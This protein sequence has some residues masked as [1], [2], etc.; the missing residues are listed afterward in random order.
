MV[1][2]PWICSEAAMRTPSTKPELEALRCDALAVC[3]RAARERLS[4]PLARAAAAFVESAGWQE[5]GYARLSDHARERFGRSGR[6]VSDLACLGRSLERLPGLAEAMS[7]QDAGPPLGRVAA[8]LVG[9]VATW[10]TLGSWVDLARCIC[11]RELKAAV[12]EALA[13]DPPSELQD[14]KTVLMRLAV[15]SPVQAAFDEAADL[16]RCVEGHESTLS[17]FVEALV[18]EAQACAIDPAPD[19]HM[20]TEPLR[21]VHH[22]ATVELALAH[23][24]ARWE[25][26]APELERFEEL[27]SAAGNG[28]AVELDA[29]IRELAWLEDEMER[30]LGALLAQ[31]AEGAAWSRLR[32]AG[33]G[34]YAEQR[35]GLCRTSAR[36]RLRA[37]RALRRLPV[38]RQAYESGVIGLQ[39]ALQVSRILL[40]AGAA[41]VDEATQ[42]LW[43]QRGAEATVKRMRDEAKELARQAVDGAG[44]ST[45]PLDDASWHASL[46]REPGM[47]RRRLARYGALALTT[48]LSDVFLGLRLPAELAGD[49]MAAMQAARRRLEIEAARVPWEEKWPHRDAP[50]SLRAAREFFII[51]NRRP[52]IWVG[53]LAMLEDFVHTWDQSARRK[54]EAI[55]ERDGYR[56]AAPGCT[57]RRNLED[58]HVLYRSQGGGNE[59]GNRICICRFHHQRGEHGGLASCHGEAPLR[60]TWRLGRDGAGGEFRNDRATASGGSGRG[61]SAGGP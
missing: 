19:L 29:Q 37:A 41:Q 27:E 36:D 59:A 60:I 42:Q 20:H 35:L 31:M 12:R 43:V 28:D 32:F 8:R 58:H 51:R 25:H 53:L 17:G 3:L 47:A 48:P 1:R 13:E 49:L 39:A 5:L 45:V 15:P 16:Y 34:H 10:E 9:Q 61:R 40:S 23:S 38:V 11:V 30:R 18:G 2:G 24:T 7:G 22:Q 6:W 44:G 14:Q 26:L 56:C 33:A 4:A 57:S 50:A 54:G 55:Y 46:R 52:P 21:H